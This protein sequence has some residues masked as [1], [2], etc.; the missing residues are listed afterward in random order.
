MIRVFLLLSLF[1]FGTEYSI[2]QVEIKEDLRILFV[3]NSKVGSEGGLQHHFR[4]TIER[5]PDSTGIHTDWIAMYNRADL[6]EMMTTD[7]L[8]RIETGDDD[9]LIVQSGP[10][11]AMAE[12]LEKSRKANKE[13]IFFSEWEDNPFL[14][15][16]TWREFSEKTIFSHKSLSQ[17][18]RE[19]NVPIAPTGL[20]FHDVL[21]EIKQ[22]N[23]RDDFLFVPESSVQNDLGV[24]VNIASLL[25]VLE[26]GVPDVIPMWDPFA[27]DLLQEILAVARQ[28]INRWNDGS[29]MTLDQDADIK[30]DVSH[31]YAFDFATSPAW[32]PVLKKENRLFYIGNSFIGTEG[33]LENHFPRVLQE[34]NAPF[35]IRTRSRIFWGQRLS[36]MFQPDIVDQIHNEDEEIIIVTSGSRIYLDSFYQEIQ[37][38]DKQMLVH[39]TWGRNPTINDGGMESYREQTMD[40]VRTCRNFEDER[41]A[42]VIPCGLIFYSLL[43][44]PPDIDE[45]LR[46]DWMFMQENIHQNHLGTMINL[47]AHF[48]I[49]TG[50][51][52]VGLP[53]WDPYPPALVKAL[54]ERVWEV[55]RVWKAGEEMSIFGS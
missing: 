34:V 1:L 26:G 46:L 25:A 4:R 11:K 13:I 43:V 17:F 39:M 48:S 37:K 54:Q 27:D 3:G 31:N 2:A 50:L 42:Q 51:S 22:G 40:I 12:I 33:G 28:S 10:E 38:A 20:V 7:L 6:S 47:A 21:K 32:D 29:F 9:L 44:D 8:H 45:E 55:V 18:S 5:L 14:S 16:N 52:P 35:S 19:E 49:M 30:S 15:G 36:R 24:Y 23:L 41:N 53:M